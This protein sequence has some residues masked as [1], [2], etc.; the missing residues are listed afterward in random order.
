MEKNEMKYYKVTVIRGHLGN[1]Y[2]HG[3]ITFYYVAYNIMHAMALAKKQGGV[4]H[5]RM[6]L[7]C[8]EVTKE[9]YEANRRINA[10]NRAMCKR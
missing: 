4:K 9:E 1:R 8:Q 2:N 5:G 6:P 7:N 10:Y 3:L